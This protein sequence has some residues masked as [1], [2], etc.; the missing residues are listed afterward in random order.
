MTPPELPLFAYGSLMLGPVLRRVADS[1]LASLPGWR[2]RI[3]RGREFPA[4]LPD[5]SESVAG[6]LWD[7]LSPRALAALDAFEGPLYSRSEILAITPAGPRPA[8]AFSLLPAFAD[9]LSPDPWSLRA[10]LQTGLEPFIRRNAPILGL[11]AESIPE[12]LA[13]ARLEP[14][15]A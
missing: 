4:I 8:W 6:V 3:V 14:L 15:P 2:R 13:L 11:R 7:G 5:P 10:F 12:F 1:P 9:S